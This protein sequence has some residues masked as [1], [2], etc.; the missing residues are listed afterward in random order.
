VPLS[1]T[2]SCGVS[3]GY[4]PYT[5]ELNPGD[6]TPPYSGTI[7]APGT[8]TQEHTYGYVGTFTATLTVTD[9]LGGSAASELEVTVAGIAKGRVEEAST[10][11]QTETEKWVPYR[12]RVHNIGAT[13]IFG[14]AV[15]NY[16]GPAPIRV[17]VAG[18]EHTIPV[19]KAIIRHYIEPQPGCTRLE[20]SGDI[21]YPTEG[22]YI[23]RLAAVHLEDENWIAD[24]YLE[25]RVDV[26]PPPPKPWWQELIEI[27]EALPWWQKG[28]VV[29]SGVVGVSSGY[30]IAKKAKRE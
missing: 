5:W 27:W 18:E 2:F 14:Y 30:V 10:P 22:T 12:I 16:E 13:G 11:T 4:P 6:G 7:T 23:I 19:G 20:Q 21:L 17:R 8:W 29:V 9:A 15:W 26:K 28:L 24:D 25:F 3:G 1:V